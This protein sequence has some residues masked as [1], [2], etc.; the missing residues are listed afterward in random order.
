MLRQMYQEN[1]EL[2]L[3]CIDLSKA[4]DS[5]PRLKLWEAVKKL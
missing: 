2:H 4:C 5:V 3:L 1:T